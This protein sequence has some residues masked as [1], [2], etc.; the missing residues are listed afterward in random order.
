MPI[1]EY[2][3]TTNG[4]RFEEFQKMNSRP[5]QKCRECGGKVRKL[6]SPTAFS[7]KGGGWYKDGYTANGKSKSESIGPKCEASKDTSPPACCSSGT[8]NAKP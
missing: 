6:I 3:C 2:E 7:L 5:L 8:C 4:H 1:Y